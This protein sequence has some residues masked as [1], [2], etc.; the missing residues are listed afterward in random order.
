MLI[1][2]RL[3][4]AGFGHRYLGKSHLGLI[5]APWGWRMAFVGLGLERVQSLLVHA[6]EAQDVR[7][8]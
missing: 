1:E 3:V 7:V 6:V 4:Q 8:A 2:I 5:T